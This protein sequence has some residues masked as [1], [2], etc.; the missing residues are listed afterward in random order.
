[1]QLIDSLTTT[2]DKVDFE[3]RYRDAL[4]ELVEQK[5]Q[6]KEIVK[7]DDG[8]EDKPVVDIMVALKKSI[9]AAKKKSA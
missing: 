7:M 3:D 4:L 5:V 8:E 2:F 9:E 1:M 6:G